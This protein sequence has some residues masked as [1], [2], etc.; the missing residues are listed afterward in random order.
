VMRRK[1]NGSMRRADSLKCFGVQTDA[2][3]IGT[4]MR[5]EKCTGLVL[6]IPVEYPSHEL[7]ARSVG[8][9]TVSPARTSSGCAKNSFRYWHTTGAIRTRREIRWHEA[10]VRVGDY[11]LKWILWGGTDRLGALY[12]CRVIR[13]KPR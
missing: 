2:V 3:L 12:E 9:W 11:T 10:A 5:A 4:P 6:P 8:F 13:S 7:R 1:L